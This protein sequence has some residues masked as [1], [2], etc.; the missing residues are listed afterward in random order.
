MIPEINS[1]V[2][3]L[4]N[5]LHATDASNALSPDQL[6]A[7]RQSLEVAFATRYRDHWFPDRPSR[8]SAYRCVRIAN[9]KLDRLL[10]GAGAEVGLSEPM[11]QRLLPA[12]LTLWVDPDEVSYRIGEEGSVGV[13]YDARAGSDGLEDSSSQDSTSSPSSSPITTSKFSG[14]S[15]S[16]RRIQASPT[17]GV[18]L[19]PD[20]VNFEYLNAISSHVAG[21]AL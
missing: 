19:S 1:A 16:S 17:S 15:G 6:V 8:G 9:R 11:L 7:F 18:R 12:E 4:S 14:S 3:F 20:T 13:I 2:R 21:G 5:I 10:A